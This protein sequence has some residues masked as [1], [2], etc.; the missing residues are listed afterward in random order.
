MVMCSSTPKML[1]P[2]AF[3]GEVTGFFCYKFEK[4][5]LADTSWQ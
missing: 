2:V 3:F 5:V 4:Y 1:W